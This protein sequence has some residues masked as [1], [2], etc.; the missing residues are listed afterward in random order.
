MDRNDSLAPDFLDFITCLNARKVEF[1]LIGGYAVG[2][3]GVIRATGDID[4]LYRRTEANVRRL[5]EAMEEFGAPSNVIDFETLMAPATISM[6]GRPP[7]RIDLLGEIDG[8]SFEQVW[9]GSTEIV[10]DGEPM[11]VIGLA[12]LRA[13]KAAT[14]RAKDR[15]DL[16][17]LPKVAGSEAQAGHRIRNE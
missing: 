12:E 10:L 8:V 3:H 15:E 6:L 4:F 17:K 5:C 16:R 13:N 14:G 7:Y 2:V 1:V 9:T 11:R